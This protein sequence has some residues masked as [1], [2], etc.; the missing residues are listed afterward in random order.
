MTKHIDRE[1]GIWDI[2]VG[3]KRHRYDSDLAKYIAIRYK[4]ATS[5]ADVGCGKGDYC[6]YLKE[7]GFSIVHGYE[8]T[9]DIKKI[10]VYDDIMVLNLIIRRWVKINY[11]LVLCL[12]VGEHIPEKHEQVFIDNICEFTIKDLILSWAIPGQGGA[13]HF[14]ERP[15]LYVMKEFAKRGFAFDKSSS[16]KLRSAAS[17]RWFRNT[18]MKFERI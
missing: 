17:F 18:I 14:N 13:G 7:C 1:T 15:N 3:K 9:V 10:A 4:D 11:D 8:G 12:E 16:M 2:E 5:V 6:K